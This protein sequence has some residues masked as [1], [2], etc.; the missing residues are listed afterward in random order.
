MMAY[1]PEY[2]KG[3]KGNAESEYRFG[4]VNISKENLGLEAATVAETKAYL[5][6]S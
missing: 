2:V 6:I 1:E 3:L 4:N 5:G